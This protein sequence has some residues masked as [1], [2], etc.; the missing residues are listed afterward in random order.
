MV[1]RDWRVKIRSG[2]FAILIIAALIVPAG[3]AAQSGNG[4]KWWDV[5]PEEENPSPDYDSIL[6]SEIA[7]KLHEIQMNSNRVRVDV[8]GQSAGGRNLFLA[9]I[10]APEALGRLGQ[11]QAIRN[12]MLK[13][14]EKAQE[15]IDKFGDFK[16]PFFINGS[17]HGNE[18]TG[19]DAVMRLIETLAYDDSEEVQMILDNLIV[20]INVV[21]NPDGRVLGT[22]QNANGIDCNRDFITQSQP[23]VQATVRVFTEWNPMVVL[24]LHGFTNPKLLE[25]CTPPHNPNYEYDLYIKWALAEAE[26]MEAELFARTGLPAQIPYRDDDLGW[27]DWPPTYVPMYAMFDG[28][29]GH[30]METPLRDEGGVD[31]HYWAVWGALKFAAENRQEM[32]HDQIEMFRRG[33]LD[34]LQQPIPPELLPAYPQYEDLMIEDFPAAYVIPKDVPFQ[35][36]PQAPARLVDFLLTNGVE[37]EQASKAFT[38][39][40]VDYPAGSYVVPMNQPKRGLASTVLESGLDL[41]DIPGLYFYSPPSV[42]SNSRLWGVYTDVA[43]D[44]LGVKTHPVNN[45]DPPQGSVEGGKAGAY[46]YL[47][48]SIAAIQATNDL[49]GRGVGLMRAPAAFTDKGRDFEAG[50]FILPAS[51]PGA[52]SIANELA[53]RWGLDLFALAGP[54]E[55]AVAMYQQRIAVYLSDTGGAVLLRRFGFNFDVITRNDLNDPTKPPLTDYDVFLNSSQSSMS[56]LDA[57]GQARVNDFFAAGG[58]Y[59]GVGRNGVRFAEALGLLTF[60]YDYYSSQNAVVIVDCDE[61]DP[62]AAGFGP[63]GYGFVNGPVVFHDLGEG[64]LA[65]VTL[66]DPDFVLSGYWANWWTTGVGGLPVVIRQDLGAQDTTLIGLDPI[67]RGHPE[68]SFRFVANAIYSGL[69]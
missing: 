44:P 1:N 65:P 63:Q 21:Q 20:L 68:D 7:P 56:G 57:V 67:F 51:V 6:Y 52:K 59:V 24:D 13:D 41:S 62:V 9:T 53:N 15:M 38:L 31:A 23:E 43:Q 34:L 16:V 8:I 17:I 35:L 49:L 12:T 10:S 3:A 5:V 14:P 66:A 42:W 29:I 45:P 69:D 26:A 39:N 64:V 19:T 37:V 4:G 48:T 40:G 11:Y 32:I 22:R 25:P 50:T 28:A 30:T 54:P 46:A 27:D 33:F 61:G 18:Y 58:D 2:L 36:S 55:G 47:P 60:D